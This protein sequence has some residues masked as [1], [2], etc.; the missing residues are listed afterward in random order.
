MNRRTFIGAT[1]AALV[2]NNGGTL[3]LNGNVQLVGSLSTTGAA[4]GAGVVGGTITSNTNTGAFV[5][6]DVVVRV[7]V[8]YA[9]DRADAARTRG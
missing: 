4:T 2:L 8:Y 6:N 3:D 1:G 5:T 7:E 9:N